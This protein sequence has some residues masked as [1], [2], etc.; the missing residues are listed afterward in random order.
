MYQFE[1]LDKPIT[2]PKNPFGK[3]LVSLRG[4]WI[5]ILVP[6]EASQVAVRPRKGKMISTSVDIGKEKLDQIILVRV[7]ESRQVVYLFL[8]GR[9]ILGAIPVKFFDGI[10]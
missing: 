4:G 7:A 10:W 8:A 6:P 2:L 9:C 5:W 1:P 3:A